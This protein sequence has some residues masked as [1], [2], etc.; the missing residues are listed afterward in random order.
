MVPTLALLGTG[1]DVG[2]SLITAGIGRMLTRAGRRVAPFK[3]QNMANNAAPAQHRDGGWGEIG[4]AQALQA[5]AC[6]LPPLCC[7]NPI[8]LKSGGAGRLQVLLD[9]RVLAVEHWHRYRERHGDLLRHVIAAHAELTERSGCELVL[10]EGAGSCCELNLMPH[11]HVNLP[12]LRALEGRFL[13]IADIDRGGVF[14]QILGTRAILAATDW[15]RCAGIVVNRFRGDP[16]FFADGLAMLR[17]R[18]ALP[19]WLVPWLE[20]L[21]LPDEDSVAVERRCERPDQLDP[22][23]HQV[24]VVA[25]PHTAIAA[26][27]SDLDSDPALQVRWC[28]EPP[29]DRVAAVVLP[30]TTCTRSDADWLLDST[31]PDWL[32]RQADAGTPIVGLCGGYQ[33]LGE[34]IDDPDGLEGPAGS[35]PG[36]GLLPLRTVI[37]RDKIVRP[38]AGRMLGVA[39]VTGFELHRGRSERLGGEAL[40]RWDHGGDDGCRQ[41]SVAGSYCHG[42][43]ANASVRRQL[44]GAGSERSDGDPLD[45]LAD[46]LVACGLD[47]TALDAALGSGGAHASTASQPSAQQ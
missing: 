32:R 24:V 28:H 19:V 3:A 45:R 13:L 36:A 41:G 35:S 33:L 38:C 21:D 14:A 7:M 25:L 40:L 8:L 46:H 42:L 22:E 1:S 37:E 23:R 9:G 18:T 47:I 11:D 4:T 15:A 29:R 34:Q 2:K 31:W 27:I 20:G 6:R 39:T 30:G 26:D 5:R 16:A 17:E 10:L 12:L 43:F 44:L